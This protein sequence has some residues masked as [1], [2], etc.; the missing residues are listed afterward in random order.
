[1]ALG[2]EL[3]RTGVN[4][5]S[6]DRPGGASIRT[7]LSE[8]LFVEAM[9]RYAADAAA[10][11]RGWLAGMQHVHV[12]RAL[13][14]MHGEPS[15]PWTVESLARLVGTSRSALAERFASLVGD[16]PIQYLKRWRLAL[17]AQAL[18]EEEISI[19]R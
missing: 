8:L 11:N 1:A 18:R 14:A 4:E 7:K 5:S 6:A 17:A 3:V 13:A 2:R 9:R 15:R 12:G 19:S 10:T 16:S